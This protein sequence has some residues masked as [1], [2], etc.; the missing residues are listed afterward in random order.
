[1]LPKQNL[2]L[3]FPIYAKHKRV[4][5]VSITLATC[6]PLNPPETPLSLVVDDGRGYA[7]DVRVLDA[8]EAVEKL[9]CVPRAPAG[10][11]AAERVDS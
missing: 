2:V 6:K 3:P 8:T 7:P 1:M 10:A 11:V 4:P 9:G 5:S